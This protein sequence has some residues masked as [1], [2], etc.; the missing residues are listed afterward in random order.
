MCS[1]S[2]L[3]HLAVTCFYEPT[4][5]S[6][7]SWEAFRRSCARSV[8]SV[9]GFS[10]PGLT[11]WTTPLKTTPGPRWVTLGPRKKRIVAGRP[12]VG[13]WSK[14]HGPVSHLNSNNLSAFPGQIVGSPTSI[15]DYVCAKFIRQGPLQ[16]CWAY[17]AVTDLLRLKLPVG[18]VYGATDVIMPP[19]QG[20]ALSCMAGAH[21]PVP[22]RI[23]PKAFHDPMSEAAAFVEAVRDIV[24]A[25]NKPRYGTPACEALAFALDGMDLASFVSCFSLAAT[26]QTV[27]RMHQT[28]LGQESSEKIDDGAVT[29]AGLLSTQQK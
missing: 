10:T 23:V 12:D 9:P 27:E 17:P 25:D 13:L 5:R 26:Q 28:L 24:Q 29:A 18:F 1:N 16:S 22:C 6:S 3:D 2:C 11:F 8:P 15:N 14:T 21:A 7:S 4:G 20:K 19:E